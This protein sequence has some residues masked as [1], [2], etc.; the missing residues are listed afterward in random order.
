MTASSDDDGTP[1]KP[2]SYGAKDITVLEGL[3]PVRKR[4]GMYIGSTGPSGLHHLIWEVVDN[5]VDEA[6][7]GHCTRIDVTLLADG[8]CRVA[9]D[10]RG[11]P[12]DPHPQYKKKSG[13]EVALTILH[14]GGKFGG[15]GYK[16]SGGLHGV[17]V[18]VV[19][20]LSSRLVVE[21]DRDGNR[22]RIEF[23]KGGKPQGSLEV[24][25]TAPRGRTGTT[26]EFW[27]DPTIFEDV[28]FRAQTVLERLQMMAFLNRGLEIRFRDERAGHE[29]EVTYRYNGGIIDFVRHLNASKEALF[30]K[31]AY[32]HQAEEAQEVEV[33]LQ[34]NTGFHEGIHSFA[35]GIATGE[36]GMHEEGL[37]KALTNAMNRY[38]RAKNL[39]KEK[40]DNLLG[41]D[42]REG[43]TAILAVRLQDPQFEGQTKSKLGNVSMRS[44]VERAANEKLA[45]WLE[46][47]P[48]EARQ[49]VQKS[50][51]AARARTAARQARDLIRRKS[52]LEGAGMPGKLRDCQTRDPRDAELFIVEGDSAGGSAVQ[53]R[54]P[55]FQAILPIR[56]KILNVERARVDRMLKNNEIQALI[57]AIGAGVG[58][59]F[60]LAK[61]RYH[62]VCLLSVDGR[63]PVLVTDDEGSLSLVPIGGFVDACLQEGLDVPQASTVSVDTVRRE[64]RVSALKQVIRHRYRGN[65]HK[66]TTAYGRSITVTAGHSLLLWEGGRAVTRPAEDLGPGD[67][68]LAPR[69]LPR[70]FA[71][72]REL[73][74]LELF[75]VAGLGRGLRAEGRSVR[76]LAAE[77][78]RQ[79]QA[80]ERRTGEARVELPLEVW[81]S[82]AARRRQLGIT[83]QDMAR[84]IGHRQACTVSEFET[85][86][87]RPALSV[88]EAYLAALG[89]ETP[90]EART[91]P[92]LA[93][94]WTN[95]PDTT[96]NSRWRKVSRSRR[97]DTITVDDLSLL[98]R[99]VE[100]VAQAHQDRRLSRV[101]PVTEE[102]CYF[103]GWYAAEGSLA[104]MAQVSLSL[105]ADDDRYISG[106]TNA[107]ERV[108]GQTP[109]VHIP[110]RDPNARKLYF[111]S[112]FAARLVNTLGLGG[113]APVKRVPDLIL[114]VSE[115]MQLAFLEGYYLGDGTK[116]KATRSLVFT[117]TS[118][119]LADGLLT[120]LS[121]LG[122]IASHSVV[123]KSGEPVSVHD[124]HTVAV[125][126]KA[127]VLMLERLWRQAPNALAMRQYCTTGRTKKP[128]WIDVSDDLVALP[129]RSNLVYR[130]DGNVYDLSV[131]DDHNFIAGR[132]GGLLAKN[133]D[134]DVDGSH[135]RTLLLTFFFRQMRDLVELGH[136]YVCQPPLYSTLVGKERVYIKD[137]GAKAR[138]LDQHPNHKADFGRFK[139]LGE[140]DF[141]ELGVTTMDPSR[142]TLLQVSMEQAAIAD[143]VFSI[144]MGEDVDLRKNFITSNAKDV[145]FLDI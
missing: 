100:L 8:G 128:S 96:A 105:G 20:A 2:P 92:G 38:A 104:R 61:I 120:V 91:A 26:V 6:M 133:T 121:Q 41:E 32:F 139:G 125:S 80:V 82:L 28:E 18:S 46:E 97:V 141:E 47:H 3:E 95:T 118:P 115:E 65:M 44:L 87:G 119:H 123:D 42:I 138:F 110:S 25:G 111:H 30:K 71:P 73:D 99:D 40:E 88:F 89:A 62:K 137:D 122:I 107:I 130:F 108:F 16:V 15:G 34:W 7:A 74:L 29:Q 19:N 70:R 131:A 78:Q 142:R 85:G 37:K 48:S 127:Q 39:L 14:A 132:G 126:G 93:E 63:E 129:V 81:R 94:R 124:L 117:T 50:V 66:I 76:L 33:A 5:S 102:L 134:A 116:G 140:M 113:H 77:G 10:G 145:R 23:A 17:G 83:L 9:D 67:W 58:D 98:D 60:D 4:P 72:V 13:V 68:V 49:V 51:Q 12:V 31:V 22:H 103:L 109:R 59:E 136:V 21:V 112:P 54:N 36:G 35:N 56:G 57:G 84:A 52:A 101:L 24:V 11:I 45:E 1:S 55:M 53:A 79:V 75:V 135:I 27:P 143:E 144:L 106:I 64:P 43:L 114:N 90:P 69:R 86:R